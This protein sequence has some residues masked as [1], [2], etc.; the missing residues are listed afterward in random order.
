MTENY[1]GSSIE[2]KL[3]YLTERVH[4]LERWP[5]GD[6]SVMASA[7]FCKSLNSVLGFFAISVL[8]GSKMVA[9]LHTGID[10]IQRKSYLLQYLPTIFNRKYMKNLKSL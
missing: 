6:Q 1:P 2:G 9:V 10:I 5:T 3:I 7:S 4:V 8:S